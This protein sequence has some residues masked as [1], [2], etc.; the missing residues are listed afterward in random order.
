M[1]GLYETAVDSLCS[2]PTKSGVTRPKVLAAT[3]TVR[4]ADTQ[5]QALFGRPANTVSVFPPPGIDDSETFF[6]T[7]DRVSPGRRYVGVAAHRPET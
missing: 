7:I 5:I 2:R 1:V 6:A 3:A 4:R